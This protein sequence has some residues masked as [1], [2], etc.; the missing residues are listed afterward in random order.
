[1]ESFKNKINRVEKILQ[2]S[3]RAERAENPSKEDLELVEENWIFSFTWRKK[4]PSEETLQ[5]IW[6]AES[7]ELKFDYQAT[8]KHF[9]AMTPLDVP[10]AII[11]RFGLDKN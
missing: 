5:A 4:A 8:Q 6:L 11:E 1:M 9:R 2:Q 10:D 7:K 3:E